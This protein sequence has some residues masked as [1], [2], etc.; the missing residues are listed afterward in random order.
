MVEEERVPLRHA[1]AK[2]L[3]QRRNCVGFL[4]REEGINAEERK[5][6]LSFGLFLWHL[7]P[8]LLGTW[9]QLLLYKGKMYESAI[10]NALYER[11]E[12]G[13]KGGISF[14]FSA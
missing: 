7:W 1:Q 10:E 9:T 13:D 4:F 14:M 6:S 5:K 8:F 11:N 12:R 3:C 2:S